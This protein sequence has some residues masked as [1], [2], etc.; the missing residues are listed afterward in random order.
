VLQ[1]KHTDQRL[2]LEEAQ[3]E[4]E[5]DRVAADLQ[6]R[7]LEVEMEGEARMKQLTLQQAMHNLVPDRDSKSNC[8]YSGFTFSHYESPF[9]ALACIPLVRS[10]LYQ[11]VIRVKEIRVC[12]LHCV[13]AATSI[14]IAH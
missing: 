5:T 4:A 6:R 7:Q 13:R 2:E 3:D 10:C 1:L 8:S 9:P 14:R 12:A 11:L